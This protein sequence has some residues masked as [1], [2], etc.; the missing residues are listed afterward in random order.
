MKQ[1]QK[2]GFSQSQLRKQLTVFARRVGRE[3]ARLYSLVKK[4]LHRAKVRFLRWWVKWSDPKL[5]PYRVKKSGKAIED[6]FV[7]R[8]QAEFIELLKRTPRDVLGSHERL[9]ISTAMSF[10]ERHVSEIMLPKNQIIYV[11]EDEVLGPLTL[12]RLYKS[13]FDHFPVIND[14][15]EVVGILHTTTLNNLTVRTANQARDFADKKV[16]YLRD[17]YTFSQ[18]LAAFCRTNCYLFLV[19]DPFERIVGLLTYQMLADLLLGETPVDDFDRD[20]DRYAVA[21]RKK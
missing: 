11:Q 9:I 14:H 17:D 18:A 10:N 6:K 20:T 2:S 7:P 15:K 13:G 19:V 8:N 4:K 3:I 1:A 12:D 21:R 5:E 16:C